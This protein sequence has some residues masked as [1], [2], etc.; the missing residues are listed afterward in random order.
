MGMAGMLKLRPD[1]QTWLDDYCRELN[2]GFPGIVEE[3][4]VFGSKARGDATTDSDLDIMLIIREG[5]W[6]Q[7]EALTRPG[8][9]LAVGTDV[10][11]SY[12]VYTR[13]EWEQRRERRAPLWRTVSRDGVPVL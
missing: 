4:V 9:L 8:H 5:D 10:V 11:P 6:K 13:E 7:K 2:E 1:E 3:V 12:V